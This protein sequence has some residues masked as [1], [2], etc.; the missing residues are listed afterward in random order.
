MVAS[1]PELT[2]RILST[3]GKRSLISLPSLISRGLG[4]P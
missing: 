4:A 1:V 2:I 3:N